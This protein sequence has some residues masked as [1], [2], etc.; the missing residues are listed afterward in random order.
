MRV[1][2]GAIPESYTGNVYQIHKVKVRSG[3]IPVSCFSYAYQAG[4]QLAFEV[5][6]LHM[7]S[8]VDT[9]LQLS[10][11]CVSQLKLNGG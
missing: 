7:Q 9:I 6:H 3:A 4:M 5:S 1:R 2:S 10:I 8:Y 11:V